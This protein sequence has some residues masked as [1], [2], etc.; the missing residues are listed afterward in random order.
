AT[1]SKGLNRGISTVIVGFMA[2]FV[3]YI[4]EKASKIGEPII[5]ISSCSI[6][7][8]T[9]TFFRFFPKIKNKYDY[10]ILIFMLTFNMI[11]VSGYRVENI[12]NMAYQRLSTIVI[13]CAVSFVISLCI[14][15]IWAGEDLHRST[16]NQ[17]HG[18]VGSVKGFSYYC[19][20]NEGKSDEGYND[21][22]DSKSSEESLTT[23][24]YI[25]LLKFASKFC[26]MRARTWEVRIQ[27]SMEAICENRRHVAPDGLL[28]YCSPWIT[29]IRISGDYRYLKSRVETTQQ[30]GL[31]GDRETVWDDFLAKLRRGHIISREDSDGIF[32]SQNKTAG[33]Y[34]A[35]LGYQVMMA[36]ENQENQMDY[37]FS[38][39][40][41]FY[42]DQPARIHN[43][44]KNI[45]S[46]AAEFINEKFRIHLDDLK[47]KAMFLEENSLHVTDKDNLCLYGLPSEQWE[48]N[49][50]LEEVPPELPE[51]ALG[52]NFARDGMQ[53]K[54][55]IS[56]CLPMSVYLSDTEGQMQI[57]GT[58][59]TYLK[60]L[61]SLCSN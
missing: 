21:V 23:Y 43:D 28:C 17:I 36:A 38:N 44:K 13:G 29:S 6:L 2:V 15:P 53:E 51:Q 11:T 41:L 26:E 45:P 35:G 14:C 27:A 37:M 20:M 54:D 3:G 48:V 60:F 40:S 24:K 5:I 34:F 47:V 50:P 61:D 52:I 9:T 42:E 25:N 30:L 33:I 10:G 56:L 22:L 58:Y 7:G 19:G 57:S 49:L 55:W 8:G 12:F 46:D 31:G 59:F 32:W 39:L 1:L 16:I 4:A 18:L